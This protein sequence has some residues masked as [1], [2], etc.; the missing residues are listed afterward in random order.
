MDRAT[1]PHNQSTITLFTELDAECD[2]QTTMVNRTSNLN[3]INQSI[4]SY[5]T[6]WNNYLAPLLLTISDIHVF[7]PPYITVPCHY[8][9]KASRVNYPFFHVTCTAVRP[10]CHEIRS[11][12]RSLVLLSL[13]LLRSV[14]FQT[15]GARGTCHCSQWRTWPPPPHTH[16]H[17]SQWLS[18]NSLSNIHTHGQ[19]EVVTGRQ[20]RHS[21]EHRETHCQT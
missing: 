9:P 14:T 19:A 5:T 16:T 18:L 13:S 2:Q 6:L 12:K 11:V 4:N 7:A 1:L 17:C 10:G 15:E 8:K 21:T 3:S 20:K